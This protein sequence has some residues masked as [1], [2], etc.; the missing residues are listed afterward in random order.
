MICGGGDQECGRESG[1]EQDGEIEAPLEPGELR[2]A[3]CER[4]GKQEREQDLDPGERDPELA[5]QLVEVAVH[6]L[7]RRLVPHQL[8]DFHF[9]L[10]GHPEQATTRTHPFATR[11][12]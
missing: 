12:R 1:Q 6:A 4:D 10:I 5:Q 3:L 11:D 9:L 2:K 7:G 8:A